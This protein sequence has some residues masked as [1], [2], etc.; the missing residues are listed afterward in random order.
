MRRQPSLTLDKLRASAPIVARAISNVSTYD[1]HLRAL[2]E[3]EALNRREMVDAFWAYLSER[4]GYTTSFN[5]LALLTA[6]QQS[7]FDTALDD[8]VARRKKEA[9]LAARR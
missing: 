1:D 9:D 4:A 2:G 6:Q 7:Q 3:L 8:I 5:Q